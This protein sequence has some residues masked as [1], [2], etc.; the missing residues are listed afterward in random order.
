MLF[1]EQTAQILVLGMHASIQVCADNRFHRNT[2]IAFIAAG[3]LLEFSMGLKAL[4]SSEIIQK[5]RG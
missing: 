2:F 4:C 5:C 1:P 3:V